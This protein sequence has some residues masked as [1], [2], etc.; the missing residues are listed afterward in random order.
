MRKVGITGI[1]Y[2]SVRKHQDRTLEELAVDASRRAL[3][4]AD[5]DSIDALYVGNMLSVYSG[6]QGHLGP[7]LAD[8]MGFHGIHAVS[9]ESACGSGGVALAQGV[10]AVKSGLLDTVLVVGVEKMCHMNTPD[11]TWGLTYAENLAHARRTGISF[12]GFNAL[13]ARLYLNTYDRDHEDLAAFAVQCH[14]NGVTADHA[15][16]KKSITTEDVLSSPMVADPL[17]L[18]DSCPISDGAAA[19]I[20]EPVGEEANGF[21]EVAGSSVATQTMSLHERDD[22]LLFK[23]SQ[24]ASERAI[25]QAGIRREDLS[26][27]EAH[28]AFDITGLISLESMGFFSRG[29][30]ADGILEGQTR[31]DGRLPVNTFGGLKSRG[32]PVGATGLYQVCE[33]VMQ[34][35]GEAGANQIG[36]SAKYGMVQNV[37]AV[38]STAAVH[39][40]RGSGT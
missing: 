9:V 13:L 18:F 15:Q 14:E 32:H 31:L 21:V 34:L 38:D 30:S 1:G 36:S 35:R 24:I 4:D 37:G 6:N 2:T 26:F 17:R 40:L 19:V 28:D 16:I 3:K 39:V 12:A 33:A 8:K 27:I 7:H 10:M 25:S 20:L 11:A 23:A 5:V 29:K 22:M